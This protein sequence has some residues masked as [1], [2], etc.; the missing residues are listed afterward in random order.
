MVND[1]WT[2]VWK[3]WREVVF[4]RKNPRGGITYILIIIA[5]LGIFMP[6]Q[7]S[8]MW[9]TNSVQPILWSW[10]PIFLAISL[11]TDAFAGERERHTLETLLASRLSDQAILFGKIAAA[12]LYAWLITFV[13][14][15]IGAVTI[16]IAHPTGSFQ[17]YPAGNLVIGL[18]FVLLAALLV[19]TIGVLVSLRAQ[20]ARQAYQRMS[21]A[22]M[23]L[24]FIPVL[25][26]QFLPESIRSRIADVFTNINPQQAVI[27]VG[28]FL[29]VANV[30]L[31]SFTM[32]RFKRTHLILD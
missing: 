2:I 13:S 10:L 6:L 21:L 22:L 31:I 12:V 28:I 16:N 18:V 19:S 1:I 26:V 9:L 29:L 32:V 4:T 14:L 8:S 24:W 15:L 17:F 20:S 25:L 11:V 27:W 30:A 7:F 3:E 23:A 5:L